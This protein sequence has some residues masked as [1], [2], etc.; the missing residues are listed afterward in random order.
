M[1]EMAFILAILF[2]SDERHHELSLGWSMWYCEWVMA[3]ILVED[4]RQI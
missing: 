1:K 4:T 3:W 2:Q